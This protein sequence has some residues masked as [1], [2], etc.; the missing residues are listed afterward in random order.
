VYSKN[1]TIEWW[2]P[3]EP[4]TLEAHGFD[5]DGEQVCSWSLETA[6]PA[7]AL[8][9]TLDGETLSG[10]GH[11][12]VHAD[13]AFVDDEG[14]E[15]RTEFRPV[16]V[17]VSGHGELLGIDTGN[18]RCHESHIS[19]RRTIYFG[20]CVALVRARRGEGV[21]SIRV[22]SQGFPTVTTEIKVGVR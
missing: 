4:G 15:V 22:S 8:R 3:Y 2:V 17:F 12:V 11:D 13:I 7:A 5:A 6:G 16:H 19:P 18:I 20:R 1:N 14:R 10:D 9:V 21:I